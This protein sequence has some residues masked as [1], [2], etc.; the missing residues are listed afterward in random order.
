M[1]GSRVVAQTGKLPRLRVGR[2]RGVEDSFRGPDAN[3]TIACRGRESAAVRGNV[4]GVNLV[5]LL[6]TSMGEPGR[7]VEAH[8]YRVADVMRMLR[9][10]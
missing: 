10:H 4:T 5:V 7:L 9:R 8:R 1:H 3:M 6:L 2:I